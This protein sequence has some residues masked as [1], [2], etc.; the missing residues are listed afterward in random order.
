MTPIVSAIS[1][2]FSQLRY[3]F[4]SLTISIALIMVVLLWENLTLLRYSWSVGS[5]DSLFD[6]WWG[7]LSGTPHSMGWLAV[8][9]IIITGILLGLIVSMTWY[10][11]RKKRAQGSWKRLFAST[12]TGTLAAV[13]GIGCIACGP[14]LVGTILAAF[15]ATG[16]LLLLPFHGAELGFVAILL[17]VYSIH[18]VS[19]IITAPATC[20]IE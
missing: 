19:K 20:A 1:E 17:L 15:G 5:A 9:T 6:L 4:L 3:W 7:L 11:W 16:L 2:V 14:L 8:S 13:L 12:G 18:T 10:A